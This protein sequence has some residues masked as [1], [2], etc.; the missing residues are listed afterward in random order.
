MIKTLLAS[1]GVVAQVG[2]PQT[3]PSPVDLNIKTQTNIAANVVPPPAQ[4]SNAGIT[5]V[6]SATG[7]LR[8]V[9]N[10]SIEA[11]ASSIIKD[12]DFLLPPYKG[13]INHILPTFALKLE[14]GHVVSGKQ[15]DDQI[16]TSKKFEPYELLTGLSHERPEVVMLTNF[17][18]VFD[19]DVSQVQSS[20][21]QTVE[22]SGIHPFM[23]DAGQFLDTQIQS[24]MLQ[25]VNY[26]QLIRSIRRGFTYVGQQ[27]SDRQRSFINSIESL[28]DSTNFL[29]ELVRNHELLKLQLDL[30]N[31]LHAVNTHDVANH[32]ISNF[33][34]VRNFN[35][36]PLLDAA[37]N[38]LPATY[39]PTDL[40]VRLGYDYN[41]V[42]T[43]FASTK[44]WLQLLI[45]LKNLLR[46]HSLQFLDIDTTLQKND[47][48]AVN[49]T[50][51]SGNRFG[52]KQEIPN[53][54]N[55]RTIIDL[56]SSQVFQFINVINQTWQVLYQDTYFKND[57]MHFAALSN[58][59]SK[60]F[61]YSFGLAKPEVK[62][63]L[64]DQF[65]YGTSDVGNVDVFDFI[66]GRF[67]NNITD[68]PSV[69]DASLTSIAQRQVSDNVAVVTLESKYLEGDTGTLTP[70]SAYYVDHT[71]QTDGNSF[72]TSRLDEL[73]ISLEKMNKNFNVIVNDMNLLSTLVQDQR[74][75]A[76]FSST[77]SS[78]LSFINFLVG[79]LVDV[80]S[81][82]T[83]QSILN[84]NL[85][86]VFAHA[87]KN[88]NVKTAL[89]LFIMM[90][91]S[92]AYNETVPFV[93]STLSSDNT[94][95]TDVLIDQIIA[96]LNSS[97]PQSRT[98]APGIS[99]VP[100]LITTTTLTKETIKTSLKQGTVLLRFVE[101]TMKSVLATF[102]LDGQALN[103]DKTRYGGYLDTVIMMVTFDLILQL[104]T[105]YGNQSIVSSSYN[106][107]NVRRGTFAFVISRILN[108]HKP[109]I[110]DLTSRI[111]RETSL[112]QQLIYSIINTL[113]RLGGAIRNHSNYLNSPRSIQKLVEISS[114]INNPDMLHML[115]SEQQIM[116]LASSVYDIRDRISRSG[117]AIIDGDVDRDGDFDSD[118]EI[119]ILDDSVVFSRLKNAL[120]GMLG[121][122]EFASDEGYNKKILTVGIPL[123]FTQRIK[124]KINAGNVRK[125]SFADK[126][127]DIV[128]IKVYKVDLDNS[129]IVYKSQQFMFEMSRFPV[130][131][132]RYFL[133]IPEN[134][135]LNDVIR[136]I[137]TRDFG[138]SP[139][140]LTDIT[141]WSS[142]QDDVPKG[143]K[144][145]FDDKTYSF[146]SQRQ[147]AEIIR[148]HITSYIL[149]IYVRLM[150]GISLADY[151][152]DLVDPPRSMDDDFVKLITEHRLNQLSTILN[153]PVRS[154]IKLSP[155]GG[156][157]F[158]STLANRLGS[159]LSSPSG[160]ALGA[161]LGANSTQRG[162][163][164]SI[165]PLEQQSAVPAFGASVSALSSRYIDAAVHDLRVISGMSRI[166]L[167]LSNPLAVSKR[168][169]L[170]K[171]FDRVFNLVID[172]DEFEID[173]DKTV[174]TPQGKQA[175]EQMIKRGD[176]VPA[177]ENDVANR[178]LAIDDLTLSSVGTRSFMQARQSPNVNSFRLKDRD[179]NKGDLAFE[180]YFVTVETFDE[181]ET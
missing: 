52:L 159:R 37:R 20:M 39:V 42:K 154:P 176:I 16:L 13:I 23:T 99:N 4:A 55:V 139:G 85:G 172:P 35:G 91:I 129:D 11:A 72:D 137:P 81:G 103:G 109:S 47:S 78:P 27:I 164:T 97:V 162:D 44:I 120:Y 17:L 102:R 29:L 21:I 133:T 92:R 170:P 174:V 100:G 151:H 19:K 49:L 46:F 171:Q 153:S 117:A 143:H 118:D 14:P 24:R 31:N 64:Q 68:F 160:V 60:E 167:P 25:Y 98:G 73:S 93:K 63:T 141:Y 112:T 128:R 140:Q 33:T 89:F 168:L 130:R 5:G 158:S 114:I 53:L 125:S 138:Q 83:L 113:Q 77:L 144:L 123:G 2:A 7:E 82:T 165:L 54:P 50:K 131:N 3:Q 28:K 88:N 10:I 106:F 107:A 58:L 74:D 101:S 94:P 76:S 124:Q 15:S 108:N 87:S 40:L 145:A 6:I 9:N 59:L 149:E 136:A 119:K 127:A 66:I 1:N 12:R 116:M 79:Q 181:D 161:T 62:R 18:P 67:G 41:H 32:H 163:S 110:A 178:F 177:S 90:K 156:V 175:L 148:N 80:R 142:K 179:K 70:G 180:K 56:Q 26:R 166:T 122:K 105:K 173:Y 43:T 126:Q 48:N 22:N 96:S 69:Q 104:I 61:R 84:D 95:V 147:K 38:L 121:H 75:K 45:E 152:F 155:P 71:L 34:S 146:L 36:H 115:M 86:S 169:L 51:S 157:L 150:T 134:P 111:E 132:D 57:E 135:S 8:L 30:R 65:L